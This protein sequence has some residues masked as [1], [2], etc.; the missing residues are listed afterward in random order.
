MY[1]VYLLALPLVVY[2]ASL[3]DKNLACF[4]DALINNAAHGFVASLCYNLIWKALL[5]TLMLA[6]PALSLYAICTY[7]MAIA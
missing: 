6:D 3:P 5:A 1:F 2:E 7:G 4:A